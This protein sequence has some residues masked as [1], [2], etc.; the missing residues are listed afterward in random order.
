MAI[1]FSESTI[2]SGFLVVEPDWYGVKFVK[3]MEKDSKDKKSKN[4][5][6]VADVIACN[7]GEDTSK[8]L[9]VPVTILINEKA[10]WAALPLFKAA[11]G[12]E[13]PEADVD[14]EFKDLVGVELDAY[15]QRGKRQDGTSQNEMIEFSPRGLNC[16]G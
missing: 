14:Y 10:D 1:R 13:D 11:N 12:G 6:L 9:G 8:M 3:H 5:I 7:E 16:K 2:K 15:I 4:H